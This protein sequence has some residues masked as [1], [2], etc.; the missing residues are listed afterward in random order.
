[1]YI[2]NK[3]LHVG[4]GS[5]RIENTPF[6]KLEWEELRLD[7]DPKNEPDILGSITNMDQVPDNSIDAVYSSHNIEHLYAYEVPKA[8]IEFKR[9][10]NIEGFALITCPDLKTLFEITIENELDTPIARWGN[11]YLTP[12]DYIFGHGESI[13][14]GNAV[15]AH[16]CGFTKKSLFLRVWLV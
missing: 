6:N 1:M 3:L 15:M 4:C 10:L 9:V 11:Y 16:K 8:L 12:H 13:K 14:N 7:I 2:K 5:N